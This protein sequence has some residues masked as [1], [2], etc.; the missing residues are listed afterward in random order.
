MPK[1][2]TGIELKQVGLK[3]LKGIIGLSNNKGFSNIIG[4][5][6]IIGF[7]NGVKVC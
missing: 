7:S 5:S 3:S 2:V 1:R 6:N 4:L